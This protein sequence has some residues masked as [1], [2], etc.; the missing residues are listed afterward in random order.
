MIG[1][2]LDI[3][4]SRN[5]SSFQ[6]RLDDGTTF[7]LPSITIAEKGLTIGTSLGEE[8]VESLQDL[9]SLEKAKGSALRY[10]GYRPRSEGEVRAKLKRLGTKADVIERTMDYLKEREL[11]NDQA[12]VQFWKENRLTFRPR[13]R[14]LI[15]QEL[16]RKGVDPLVID[17]EVK[18]LDDQEAAYQAAQ[19]KVRTL[20]ARDY[21]SFREK[22]G[23][24]LRRRGF[25]YNVIA[26]TVER[27]W[28]QKGDPR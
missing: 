23:S 21:A 8:E 16:I 2:I 13:S 6:V 22:L 1:T 4:P 7:S 18:E 11:V 19:R 28:E 20:E 17:E 27:L 14:L 26:L 5:S 10:L 25:S 24:F 9:D 12:F 15:K 3:S